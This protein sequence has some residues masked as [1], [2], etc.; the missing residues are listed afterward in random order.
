MDMTSAMKAAK[1]ANRYRADMLGW[2]WVDAFAK[3]GFGDGDGEIETPQVIAALDEAGYTVESYE[4]G[5]HN[6]FIT[7][8][9]DPEGTPWGDTPGKEVSGYINPRDYL[10]EALTVWLDLRFPAYP[11]VDEGYLDRMPEGG[12]E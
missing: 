3:F 5:T 1:P 7:R 10:P 6:H 8:L 2:S 4:G 11:F 9:T 12:P